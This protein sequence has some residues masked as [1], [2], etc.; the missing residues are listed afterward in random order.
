MLSI[1]NP[2]KIKG[3]ILAYPSNEGEICVWI[4]SETGQRIRLSDTFHP[5][6]YVSS[7]EESID[8]LI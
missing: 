1:S 4:I 7:K 8:P 2:C 5:K 3:W 6:I